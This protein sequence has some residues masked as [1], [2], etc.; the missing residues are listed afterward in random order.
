MSRSSSRITTVGASWREV[1][2]LAL[3]LGV[4]L[5]W[6]H[7]HQH[8]HDDGH[9]D[10]PGSCELCVLGQGGVLL[11]PATTASSQDFPQCIG[12]ALP[13]ERMCGIATLPNRA[14]QPRPP[15]FLA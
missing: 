12:A 6:G 7:V 15:P 4:L 3:L 9:A 14:A 1:A 2:L 5:P 11:P 8:S 13:Q 10:A